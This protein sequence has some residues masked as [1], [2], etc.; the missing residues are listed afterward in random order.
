MGSESERDEESEP[1]ELEELEEEIFNKGKWDIE[2]RRKSPEA[3]GINGTGTKEEEEEA[4]RLAKETGRLR[5]QFLNTHKSTVMSSNSD[6]VTIFHILAARAKEKAARKLESLVCWAVEIAGHKLVDV[7]HEQRTAFHIAIQNKNYRIL[8]HMLAAHEQFQKNE[9]GSSKWDLDDILR[10]QD[11]HNHNTVVHLAIEYMTP[12]P[13]KGERSNIVSKLVEKAS[14]TTLD[15]RNSSSLTALHLAVEG[16]R[17]SPQ[18]VDIVKSLIKRCEEAL[19][20][21]DD[22]RNPVPSAYQRH[23]ATFQEWKKTALNQQSSSHVNTPRQGATKPGA[24]LDKSMVTEEIAEGAEDEET[25]GDGLDRDAASR[26]EPSPDDSRFQ[27]RKPTS[28]N[29]PSGDDNGF[30][31]PERRDTFRTKP[32]KPKER[33]SSRKPSQEQ[34]K[35][36][37]RSSG[38]SN[39]ESLVN[40]ESARDIAR[41]LKHTYLRTRNRRNAFLFL[42]GAVPENWKQIDFNLEGK[43]GEIEEA[44]FKA[45]YKCANLEDTLKL[46]HIPH[47]AIKSKPRP[48][49]APTADQT[50]DEH[51]PIKPLDLALGRTDLSIIFKWL[52]EEAGVEKIIELIVDDSH[53]PPHTD[54]QIEESVKPFD[55]EIWNWHK[56]DLCVET[57]AV[58]APN[59]REVNLYWSGNNAVLRGWSDSKGGLAQLRH[60]RKVTVH[61]Q[62]GSIEGSERDERNFNIFR[63]RLKLSAERPIGQEIEVAPLRNSSRQPPSNHGRGRQIKDEKSLQNHRW[64]KCMDEFKTF[65]NNAPIPPQIVGGRQLNLTPIKIAVIDDGIDT[66][67]KDLQER[68]VGGQCFCADESSSFY[69]SAGGHGTMM[70]RLI[71]RVFPKAQIL[72]LKLDEHPQSDGRSQFSVHSATEAIRW[73]KNYGVS[74]INMSWSIEKMGTL[75][76]SSFDDLETAVREADGAK[77]LMFCSNNDQGETK[78]NSYPGRRTGAIKIG[79]A[80]AMGGKYHY[81]SADNVD[82]LFPGRVV[83]REQDE[84]VADNAG[85][86]PRNRSAEGSSL[87]TAF[88][89][90]LAGLVLYMLQLT[91]LHCS[92]RGEGDKAELYTKVA[93]DPKQMREVLAKLKTHGGFVEVWKAFQGAE[94]A[95]R[96][97]GRGKE[98]RFKVMEKI[99]AQL[100]LGI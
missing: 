23:C 56:V 69:V 10:I 52:G 3:S 4:E 77:I 35:K 66:T 54:R 6:G 71:A 11:K 18:Q 38:A 89:S 42:Y 61:P 33:D 2:K 5:I 96:T 78:D 60:L 41:L 8:R 44:D 58:A 86:G 79:A 99:C 16:K 9:D 19:D 91:S 83:E 63:E 65:I 31:K 70:A 21:Y 68:V 93:K 55:V 24:R 64:L 27:S 97:S 59:V 46:V 47:L 25:V 100:T 12:C 48:A 62:S 32:T 92:I 26:Q 84:E 76:E 13:P 74:I 43:E 7:D 67:H 85:A 30:K 88:A 39:I 34:P 22:N 50:D 40:E 36:T 45:G 28:D 98:T 51:I 14:K 29:V 73:A 95:V 17:C 37:T 82:F 90:G 15:K 49:P 81:V 87:A 75:P 57:I 72:S 20:P 1:E 94:D 80:T 53:P